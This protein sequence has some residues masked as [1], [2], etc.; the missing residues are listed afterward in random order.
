MLMLAEAKVCYAQR[1]HIDKPDEDLPARRY[2]TEEE[3]NDLN[4]MASVLP[5]PLTMYLECIGNVQQGTSVIT[6]NLNSSNTY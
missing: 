4:S 5:L 3:L 6:D 1:A 2:Y